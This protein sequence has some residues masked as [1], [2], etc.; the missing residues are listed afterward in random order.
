MAEKDILAGA[1]KLPLRK[2]AKLARD[3][4]RS[5][6]EGEDVDAESAWLEEIR[7]RM[8]EVETGAVKLEEWATVRNRITASLKR[9]RGARVRARAP[10]RARQSRR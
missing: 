9:A 2:R 3:L 1:L 5:L 10:S 6:D 4:L 7:R 8:A